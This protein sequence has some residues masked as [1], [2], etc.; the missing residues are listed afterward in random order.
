MHCG[1]FFYTKHGMGPT[2]KYCSKSCGDR[3]RQVRYMKRNPDAQRK[4]RLPAR[5]GITL[6]EYNA[7]HAEQDGL[8]GICGKPEYIVMRGETKRLVIDHDHDT[9][10]VRA[11]LCDGCNTGLAKFKEN[12]DAL[13]EAAQYIERHKT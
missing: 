5:Y 13:R 11:L 1:K 8:C 4:W 12:P 2:P 9:G 10:K 6:D 3:V 7:M